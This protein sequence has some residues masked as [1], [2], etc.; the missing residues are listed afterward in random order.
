[1]DD[2]SLP[3]QSM[4][5]S[6]V[7]LSFDFSGLPF[8]V[9]KVTFDFEDLGGSENVSV[10]R[11]A[12]VEGELASGEFSGATLTVVRGQTTGEATIEGTVREFLIGG[13]EFFLDNVCAF[14]VP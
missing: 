7:N 14:E 13:Q 8:I 12:I 4:W 3:G 5:I 11:S 9:G 1:M 10:N 6:N 2:S